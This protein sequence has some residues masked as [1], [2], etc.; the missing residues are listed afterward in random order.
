MI[1]AVIKI[2]LLF[3]TLIL[4]MIMLY[5]S[6]YKFVDP[7]WSNQFAAWGY[8]DVFMYFIAS[9]EMVIAIL[10]FI[11]QTRIYALSALILFLFGAIYTHVTN[12]EASESTTAVF[13]IGLTIATIAF[14]WF[15]DKFE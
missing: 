2:A 5:S 11:K 1:K 14:Q 10:I 7:L 12:N 4:S 6:V 3:F 8:S 15:D 13:L 9:I